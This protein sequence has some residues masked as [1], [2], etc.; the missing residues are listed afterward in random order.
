MRQRVNDVATQLR[1]TGS[2]HEP[3]RAELRETRKAITHGWLDVADALDAH[4]EASLAGKVRHFARH[5]PRVLTDK[6][7][8][9]AALLQH[10]AN[11]RLT[12][13]RISLQQQ[14]RLAVHTG[15]IQRRVV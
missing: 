6:E 4:G 11:T 7:R 12:P 1:E 8:V 10:V 13:P 3:A 2:L 5:L 9:P 15:K 14:T